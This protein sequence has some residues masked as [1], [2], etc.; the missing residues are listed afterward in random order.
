ML[1]EKENKDI[2]ACPP[3]LHMWGDLLLEYHQLHSHACCFSPCSTPAVKMEERAHE[4]RPVTRHVSR[5]L[6]EMN[7]MHVAT[8]ANKN[9]DAFL[10]DTRTGRDWTK[11][12]CNAAGAAANSGRPRIFLQVV[13]TSAGEFMPIDP[14]NTELV[15][16][17]YS[18]SMVQIWTNKSAA[19]IW[20]YFA[21]QESIQ[22]IELV[23][24]ELGSM[25]HYCR[26]W[27][28]KKKSTCTCLIDIVLSCRTCAFTT[29]LLLEG[30]N[31]NCVPGPSLSCRVTT[32]AA[33]AV[34]SGFRSID[35]QVGITRSIS[36]ISLAFPTSLPVATM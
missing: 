32:A 11:I 35:D 19:D 36:R 20:Q 22:N 10:K 27:S 17:I 25:V 3:P 2:N 18:P 28:G 21:L 16:H 6:L 13:S 15:H 1:S 14:W 23:T 30:C 33:L 8:L 5:G 7:I 9:L 26:Y 24:S 29:E 4:H 34:R 12:W 31:G